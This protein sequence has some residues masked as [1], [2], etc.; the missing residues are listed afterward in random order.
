MSLTALRA[1][2]ER[3]PQSE[4][5]IL[6]KPWVADLYQREPF[7]NRMIPYTAR[8]LADKWAAGRAVARANFDCA[9]LLQHA[10]EA[11][12]VACLAGIPE[13]IRYARDGRSPLLTRA[14]PVPR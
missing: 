3:S 11:A 8:T 1:L 10:F 9:L 2:R 14:I 13:R 7:C 4:M 12:A 5:A 6:A